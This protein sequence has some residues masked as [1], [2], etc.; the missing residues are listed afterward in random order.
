MGWQSSTVRLR[1]RPLAKCKSSITEV[2]LSE[3]IRLTGVFWVERSDWDMLNPHFADR[4]NFLSTYE[5]WRPLAE[6]ALKVLSKDGLQGMKVRANPQEFLRWCRAK[7]IAIDG[8][9]RL[10]YATAEKKQ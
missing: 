7:G 10:E 1:G 6:H 5:Q 2:S 8:R 4:T 9:A 3:P